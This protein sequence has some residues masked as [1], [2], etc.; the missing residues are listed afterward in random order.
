MSTDSFHRF[1][2]LVVRRPPRERK[3]PGSNPA[4]IHSHVAETLSNQPTNYR[5]VGLVGKTSASRGA[6]LGSIPA[7]VADLFPGRI[8]PVTSQL[9]LQWLPCQA[10]GV[11]GSALG[12]VGQESLCCDRERQPVRSEGS[13][14]SV[15]ARTQVQ[16][17][18][19][20]LYT[21]MLLG[22]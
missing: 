6:D 19:C 11:I 14:I 15:A 8:I 12:L 1:V 20:L 5:L 7:L 16:A 3:I 13:N 17:D 22:R 4:E 2:G 18:L 10:P 21:G 9:V